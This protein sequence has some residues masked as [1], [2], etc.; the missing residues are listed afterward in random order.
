MADARAAGR[1]D[2]ARQLVV[3]ASGQPGSRS[4]AAVRWRLIIT[5]SHA[6][7]ALHAA[8]RDDGPVHLRA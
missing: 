4:P 3:L 5:H 8:P 2:D 1:I 7:L 6:A